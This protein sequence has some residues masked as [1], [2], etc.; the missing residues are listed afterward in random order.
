[1]TTCPNCSRCLPLVV[2]GETVRDVYELELIDE[3]VTTRPVLVVVVET[4]GAI[5]PKE[6]TT[7]TKTG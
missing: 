5:P 4:E 7:G 2:S 6:P 3:D 1:M